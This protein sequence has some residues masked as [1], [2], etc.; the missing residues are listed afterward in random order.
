MFLNVTF[1]ISNIKESCSVLVHTW[2]LTCSQL[3]F[4]SRLDSGGCIYSVG[5]GT[6]SLSRVDARL[7]SLEARSHVQKSQNLTDNN[8]RYIPFLSLFSFFF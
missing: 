7:V 6:A 8:A 3:E 5:K 2:P 1:V 4:I